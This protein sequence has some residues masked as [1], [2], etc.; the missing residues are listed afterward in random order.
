MNF[1]IQLYNQKHEY[2]GAGASTKEGHKLSALPVGAVDAIDNSAEKDAAFSEKD[3]GAKAY[4]QIVTPDT[5]HILDN[6][7]AD[8]TG[9]NLGNHIFPAGAVKAASG[10]NATQKNG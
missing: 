6:D 10:K 1:C 4:L 7:R 5:A 3:F 8:I 9:F 2:Y